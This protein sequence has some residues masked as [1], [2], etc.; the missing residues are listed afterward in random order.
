[1][2]YTGKEP[3]RAKLHRSRYGNDYAGPDE[4]MN[5]FRVGMTTKEVS[6]LLKLDFSEKEGITFPAY[7]CEEKLQIDFKGGRVSSVHMRPNG[8]FCGGFDE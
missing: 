8:S 6:R 5:A 3:S 2:R 1:M 4:L 7:R